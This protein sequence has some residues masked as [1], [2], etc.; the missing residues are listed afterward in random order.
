MVDGWALR[1]NVMYGSWGWAIQ[2]LPT[3]LAWSCFVGGTSWIHPSPRTSMHHQLIVHNASS[4]VR[5]K[6][7]DFSGQELACIAWALRRFGYNKDQNAVFYM[8]ER[9]ERFLQ[10]RQR[11]LGSRVV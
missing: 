2:H 7:E 6:F 4:Q 8:L 9:Q 11:L 5:E 1:S 10:V 3:V